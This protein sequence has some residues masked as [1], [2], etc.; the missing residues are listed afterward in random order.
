ML[1]PRSGFHVPPTLDIVNYYFRLRDNYDG[2]VDLPIIA[3][4]CPLR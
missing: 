2:R 1:T 3:H 4:H